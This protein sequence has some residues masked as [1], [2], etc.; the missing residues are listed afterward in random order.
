MEFVKP[1]RRAFEEVLAALEVTTA[2]FVGDRLYDDVW[3]A[4]QA[5]LK[6]V[7]VR[8]DRTP[9]HDVSPDGVIHSLAELPA[10]VT[11]LTSV[12]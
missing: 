3:G 11:K 10:L 4:Q 1:D 6:A 9:D 2:V 5:G 7:W 12:S 8:N